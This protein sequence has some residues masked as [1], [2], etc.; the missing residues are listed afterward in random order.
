MFDAIDGG[1]GDGIGME[2]GESN[3]IGME[4][5]GRRTRR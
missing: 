2:G 3:G 1:D 4:R 5:N